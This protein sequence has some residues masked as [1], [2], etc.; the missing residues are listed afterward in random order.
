MVSA[1]GGRLQPGRPALDRLLRGAHQ[2][3][4]RAETADS[5]GGHAM[6]DVAYG[7]QRLLRPSAGPKSERGSRRRQSPAR[8]VAVRASGRLARSWEE[9]G[10]Q[11][12]DEKI[13]GMVSGSSAPLVHLE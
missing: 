1:A 10:F 7:R 8:G 9:M 12:D 6:G 11:P 4:G 13:A 3:S 2:T 5:F